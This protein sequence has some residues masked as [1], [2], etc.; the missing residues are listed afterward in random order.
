MV[1]IFHL[2]I[3]SRPYVSYRRDIWYGSSVKLLDPNSRSN[4]LGSRVLIGTSP[5]GGLGITGTAAKLNVNNVYVIHNRTALTSRSN[6][7]DA[8]YDEEE[9]RHGK[10]CTYEEGR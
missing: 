9:L 10:D 2:S 7:C 3:F 4:A 8:G 5:E 6:A 1:N